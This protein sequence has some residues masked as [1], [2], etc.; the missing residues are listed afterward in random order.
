MIAGDQAA[1]VFC[2]TWYFQ[3]YSNWL[4]ENESSSFMYLIFFRSSMLAADCFSA[5]QEVVSGNKPLFDQE[6]VVNVT[7]RYDAYIIKNAGLC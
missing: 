7:N 6:E 3:L 2:S 5:V 4:L 1:S